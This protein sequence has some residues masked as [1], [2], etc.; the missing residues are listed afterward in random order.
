M[1]DNKSSQAPAKPGDRGAGALDKAA[2]GA[3]GLARFVDGGPKDGLLNK[4]GA[5]GKVG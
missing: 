5:F 4:E 2:V 1:I 3:V